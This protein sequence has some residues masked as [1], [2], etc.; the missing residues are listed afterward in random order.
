MQDHIFRVYDIRGIVGTELLVDQV[1]DCARA[2]ALYALTRCPHLTTVAIGMDGRIHSPVIKDEFVRGLR[3]SGL[4]VIFIG[5]CPTPVVSFAQ[6]WLP[7]QAACMI[8]ASHNPKDYNGIKFFLDKKPVFNKEI[9]AIHA[10]F[11]AKNFVTSP[12][13]GSYQEYLLLPDYVALLKRLFPHLVG[14]P[15]K[16]VF[17]CGNGAVGEVLPAVCKALEL[18]SVSI[19]YGD[20]DG[21]YPNHEADPSVEENLHDL[22]RAVLE[23]QAAVGMAFDGDG[24]RMGA[25]TARGKMVPGDQLLALLSKPVLEALPGTRVV[26]D[27]KC[28]GGLH[29]FVERQGGQICMSPSGHAF[30][31]Q[32][33]EQ[34]RALVGGELSCHFFFKDRYFG[35]DDGVY[36]ALRLLELLVLSQRTLESF[37]QEFPHRISSPELRISCKQ[38]EGLAVITSVIDA[39]KGVPGLT[40]STIDGVRVS[41]KEGWGLLRSSNTQPVICL[42]LEADSQEGLAVVRAFF[43]ER[44]TKWYSKK[45]LETVVRW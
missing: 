44:L 43:I 36:A 26:C 14:A 21:T 19:L 12:C 34:E 3:D 1:Y 24:D 2:F 35:Y 20:V 23:S 28:S 7:V 37:L 8:T 32:K 9:Q 25:V 5:V 13:K 42:R 29:E 33:M 11:R 30:I 10:L 38:G 40:L 17:D 18:S 15:L 27:A 4:S 41:M 39:T 16:I 6:Y 45:Y 22:Q 31:R